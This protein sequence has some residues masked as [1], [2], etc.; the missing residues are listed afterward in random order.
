MLSLLSVTL[1]NV[2][3]VNCTSSFTKSMS[4]AK[5]N[6]NSVVVSVPLT[7]FAVKSFIAISS[8]AFTYTATVLLEGLNVYPSLVNVTFTFSPLFTVIL[9]IAMVYVPSLLSVTSSNVAPSTATSP[10]TKSISS[11]SVNFNCV[12]VVTDDSPSNAV[13]AVN[14][15]STCLPFSGLKASVA[16][17]RSFIA[18]FISL[19]VLELS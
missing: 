8:G 9:L 4:F 7:P 1:S 3:P 12:V 19:L 17:S 10:F 5:V 14:S 18:F 13:N 15:T 11:E 16:A 6:V 2:A